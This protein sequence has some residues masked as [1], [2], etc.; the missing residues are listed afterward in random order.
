EVDLR[1]A[2]AAEHRAQLV[3][4]AEATRLF[5]FNGLIGTHFVPAAHDHGMPVTAAPTATRGRSRRSA[6]TTTRPS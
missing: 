6:G 2:T 4:A 1:H 5:Q 3:P